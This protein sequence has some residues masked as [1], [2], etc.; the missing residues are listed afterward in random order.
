M[1]ARVAAFFDLDGTLMPLPSLERRF[2]RALRHRG[3][4]PMKNYLRWLREELKL[5]PGGISKLA[6]TNKMYLR[7]LQVSSES[8]AENQVDSRAHKSGHPSQLRASEEEGQASAPPRRNPR[9]PVPNFFEDGVER[10]AWHATQGHA[11]VIVSGTLAP[12][13]SSAARALEAELA[14][15]GIVAKIRVRATN[16]E[17]SEGRWRGRI[18]GEPM[19]GKAKARAVLALAEELDLDLSQSWAYGDSAQDRWMLGAVG[20]P[21][22]VNPARSFASIMRNRHWPV[23]HWQE[24]RS[25]TQRRGEHRDKQEDLRGERTTESLPQSQEVQK[26]LRRAERCT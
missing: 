1:S 8:G 21:V 14:D 20:H 7:G 9:W 4:I 23:F 2:F 17:E 25:L 15:R 12:L 18:L 26:Q 6:H 11:I 3:E 16:L 5:L 22:A 13:A 19:C 10:L 24:E